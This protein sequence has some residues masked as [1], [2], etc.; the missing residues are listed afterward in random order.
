MCVSNGA[1]DIANC[2]GIHLYTHSK[3]HCTFPRLYLLPLRNTHNYHPLLKYL[4]ELQIITLPC[5]QH[6]CN[7]I[8]IVFD[9]PCQTCNHPLAQLGKRSL[10]RVAVASSRP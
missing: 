2:E 3:A 6:G 10:A 1:M 8:G 9:Q 4:Y 7:G 5:L